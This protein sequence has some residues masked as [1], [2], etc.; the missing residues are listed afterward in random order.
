M[1]RNPILPVLPLWVAVLIAPGAG[2]M[3]GGAFP[4]RSWWP[5][6]FVGVFLMLWALLGRGFRTGALIGFVAAAT[7]WGS[8]IFWLTLFLGPIPW[9]VLTALESMCYAIALGFIAVALVRVPAMWPSRIG[10]LG[11]TPLVIGGL[12][13]TLEFITSIWPYGGFA[14]GRLGLSQSESPFASLSAWVGVSGLSFVIVWVA[15]FILQLLRETTMEIMARSY[16]AITAVV[17]IFALP[18][19]P[20]TITGYSRIAAVQGNSEGGVFTQYVPGENLK[21]HVSATLPLIGEDVDM[22]IWPENSSDFDPSRDPN[23]AKVFDYITRE[24]RAPL[25]SGTITHSD[26]D[27]Y[28]NTSLLWRA[29]EGVIDWYD[30]AHPVPFAEYMPNR[31]FFRMFAPELVDLVTKEYSFGTR[32]NVYNVDGVMVGIAICF[33]ISDDHLIDEMLDN[34]A[35]IIIAQ[36]NNADFG[37]TDES[38]QQLSISRMRAR[39]TGRSVVNISTVGTSAIIAPDGHIINQ[40]P[41][42]QSGAMV[43]EVPLSNTITPA[44]ILGRELKWLIAGLGVAGLVLALTGPR[45]TRR[46][47]A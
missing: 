11:M 10:R 44:S 34:N 41:I 28:Y 31:E 12:W 42:F 36:N 47:N 16:I 40:L 37:H 24:M 2:A 8:L 13:S 33:D 35:D 7:F 38:L 39:E 5:L 23:T 22:V 21:E 9:S 30:K 3:V 20:I 17:A 32:N 14:W 45:K 18:A 27:T 26:D 4:D 46:I 43:N 15:A 29:G 25:I 6:A 19:W 1:E